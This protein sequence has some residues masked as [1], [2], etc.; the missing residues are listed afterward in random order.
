MTPKKIK[1][2]LNDEKNEVTDKLF[3]LL[4]LV[5]LLGVILAFVGG[6]VVGEKLIAQLSTGLT[7]VVFFLI[8]YFGFKTRHL[9]LS[10]NIVSF[11]LIFVV[12]PL[13]FFTSGGVYGGT[14]IW[15]LFD[16][17]FVGLI[18]SGRIR[19]FYFICGTIVS[20]VCWYLGYFHPEL[21]IEH[22]EEA[23]YTDSFATLVIVAFVITILISYQ[24]KLFRK[25]TLHS[26]EQKKEIEE[27]N[28]AQNRFFSS[29]SHEIR[30]P[31]NTIIGLNEMILR[32][33]ISD[34]V[35][36]DAEN[37]EMAS[38]MLLQLIN[39]I[40]DMSKFES[41]QMTI[42][43]APYRTGE[44]IT[45]LVG[46]FWNRIHEK[47]MSFH[48][49]ISPDLPDTLIGD[50]VRIKQILINLI[51]NAIKYTKEGSVTLSV[52]CR[53]HD[54]KSV[55][56]IYSVTDTGMGIKKENIPH[57]FTAF[58]RIDEDKNKYIEGTGL[59]LSIVKQ[60]VDL[61][62][63]KITVNSIYTQ[64]TTF[65]IEL[66]QRTSGDKKIDAKNIETRH[67]GDS[68]KVYWQMF[69]APDANVLVV[70]DTPANLLVVKKLLRDTCVKVTTVESGAE[71]LKKTLSTHYDVILMDH[72]MPEMDGI[73][74][75]HRIREQ[76]GGFSKQAKIVA[77]TANA[78]AESRRLYKKERFDGYLLKPISGELL[79]KEILRLLPPE[80][81][82]ITGGSDDILENSTAWVNDYQ[83]KES[84]V[85]ST[86]SVSDIPENLVNL[87]GILIEPLNIYTDEGVFRDNVDIDSKGILSYM[88][89]K[90]KKPVMKAISVKS[91]EQLF[92]D[93]LKLANNVVHVTAS[94]KVNETSYPNAL[95]AAKA[96]DNVT[97]INTDQFSG[98]QGLMVLE[99]SR[100]AKEGYSPEEINEALVK[101]RDRICGSFVVK[102]F[103]AL[104]RAGQISA[105]AA[106]IFN[107]FMMHPVIRI[108][109]GRMKVGRM[110]IGSWKH[111]VLRYIKTE[112]KNKNYIDKRLLMVSYAGLSLKDL[113]W[114]KAELD[115]LN[116]FDKI[117]YDET[118]AAIALNSGPGTV[119]FFYQLLEDSL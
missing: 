24:N 97:V 17:L 74:C 32:D 100:L 10:A 92:A 16:F 11:L 59:G 104:S 66:P 13:T 98:G 90:D 99:A 76:I 106:R 118:S 85:I 23:V 35:K 28:A 26:E 77:L 117:L 34:E 54:D 107:A 21:V 65:T 55:M 61:M 6:F 46:M 75:M 73:E 68:R 103:D 113:E 82:N 95:E 115:K 80:L 8:L 83:K 96:F 69:E 15:F 88:E 19:V 58:K 81:V 47:N 25:E 31:I 12:S 37:I 63:G 45:E 50:E 60:F 101:M 105:R 20:G 33:S 30:T 5:A 2:F 62:G 53:E 39:D 70:D 108:K 110:I 87:Y 43:P 64:G 86:E 72:M 89:D 1:A 29:M 109:H 52:Q 84:V 3:L 4:A 102:D 71:A 94:E 112:L 38:K 56:I 119:G 93:G 51:N 44:M 40:L 79:E 36:D 78:D 18:I 111:M 91:L 9:K 42:T 22:S 27:L 116:M 67:E 41:G 114:I 14:P 48:V 49:E 57:L 7:F